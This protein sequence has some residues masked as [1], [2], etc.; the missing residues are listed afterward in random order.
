M[1]A[2]NIVI[3]KLLAVPSVTAIFANRIAPIEIAQA[4]ATPYIVVDLV[5][6]VDQGGIG[7]SARY[8][9]SRVQVSVIGNGQSQMLNGAEA[10]KYAIDNVIKEAIAGCT[11]VDI[12][13]ADSDVTGKTNDAQNYFA[14]QMDFYVNWR[15]P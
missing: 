6:E 3:Q 15:K 13:K 2:L 5:S 8:Y 14:R 11:D 9:E 10:V 12:R 7:G 4:G 1:S